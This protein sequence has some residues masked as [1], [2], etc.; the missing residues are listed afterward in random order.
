MSTSGRFS[1]NARLFSLPCRRTVAYLGFLDELGD[2]YGMV[3]RNGYRVT[4]IHFEVV[5][6]VRYVHGCS[7]NITE[8]HTTSKKTS[9]ISELTEIRW[10][11]LVNTLLTESIQKHPHSNPILQEVGS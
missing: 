7:C 6:G 5:V 10:T 8:T 2:D 4:E 1:T 3:A 11:C 9:T